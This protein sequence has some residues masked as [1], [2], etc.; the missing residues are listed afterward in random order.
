MILV[1]FFSEDNG[2]SDEINRCY[3]FEY[4][5]ND[6]PAFRLYTVKSKSVL[7]KTKI[8]EVAQLVGLLF[9]D[10]QHIA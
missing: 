9:C 6:I 1:S 5:S 10:S 8:T 4:Q 3:I 2:Q 7:Q